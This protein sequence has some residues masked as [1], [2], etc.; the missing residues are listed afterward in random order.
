LVCQHNR[1]VGCRTISAIE[2]RVGEE[3]DHVFSLWSAYSGRPSLMKRLIHNVP[4]PLPS[5]TYRWEYYTDEYSIMAFPE[6]FNFHAASYVHVYLASLMTILARV[7]EVLYGV[8]PHRAAILP[9]D[10]RIVIPASRTYQTTFRPSLP[11]LTRTFRNGSIRFRLIYVSRI[12]HP[13]IFQL[14]W[15]CSESTPIGDWTER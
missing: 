4:S 10:V 8:I 15:S 6:D 3:T 5:R 14:C 2:S 12:R 1:H 7:S 11:E 9:A 13:F